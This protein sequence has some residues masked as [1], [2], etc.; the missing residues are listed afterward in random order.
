M[1]PK[2]WQ[3]GNLVP[4]RPV[5]NG[6]MFRPMGFWGNRKATRRLSFFLPS[7]RPLPSWYLS[8]S[9]T[10]LP[11]TTTPAQPWASQRGRAEP[12][13]Y[14]MRGDRNKPPGFASLAMRLSMM[15][16]PCKP[17]PPSIGASRR[18][19]FNGGNMVFRVD[20]WTWDL[21]PGTRDLRPLRPFV[22]EGVRGVGLWENRSSA[23]ERRG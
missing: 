15:E 8:R 18:G 12:R 21:E 10:Q 5:A 11:P 2:D 14:E 9:R 13:R 4:L 22:R 20:S 17:N 23:Q 6:L 1:R 19:P 7:L 3:S 16:I